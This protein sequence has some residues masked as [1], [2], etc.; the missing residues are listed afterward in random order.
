MPKQN[1]HGLNWENVGPYGRKFSQIKHRLFCLGLK[2]WNVK[3]R[4]DSSLIE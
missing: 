4:V 1:E 3:L 2:F